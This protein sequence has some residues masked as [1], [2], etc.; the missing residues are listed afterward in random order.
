[1]HRD[2]GGR[3]PLPAQHA[4]GA[5][6]DDEVVVAQEPLVAPG[7]GAQHAAVRQQRREVPVH[8]D[9]QP[10]FVAEVAELED[11]VAETAFWEPQLRTGPDG[12]GSIEFTVP[13][14]VT[15]WSVW[16]QALTRDL[17]G[18]STRKDAPSVKD[19]MV[20]PYVPR[21]FRAGD[22]AALE[23]VV[24]NASKREMSGTVELDVVDT[25]TNASVREAFGLTKENARRPFTA[26]A[27]RGTPATFPLPAPAR[28]GLYAIRATAVSGDFS[29]GELR[30]VPVLPGRMTL[31]QSRF[32]ALSGN[33]RRT[34]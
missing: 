16:V 8:R 18:G 12:S 34:M 7:A 32:V 13:D 28:P 15:A 9:E 10:A 21:F 3:P 2:L 33:D 24:D 4:P 23:V 26:A 11:L 1:M 31:S 20:R 29:D 30:P 5:V 6:D 14:S 17:K 19:L 25:E 22:R 27:G